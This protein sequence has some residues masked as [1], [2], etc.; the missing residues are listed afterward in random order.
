M[1]MKYVQK[2]GDLHMRPIVIADEV[3]TDSAVR[4]LINDAGDDIDDLMTLCE[5][6]ITSKN[7]V[8]KR[9]FLENF[10]MVREKLVDLKERDFKRLLQPVIDGNEIMKMFNLKPSQ[11]VGRLKEALKNAVLDNVVPNE[12]EPLMQLLLKKA[13]DLGLKPMNAEE[14]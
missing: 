14:K 13:A 3:V 6:D 8:R 4:R 9:Q 1:K 12:R 11:E 7:E 10:R 2:L 5:G